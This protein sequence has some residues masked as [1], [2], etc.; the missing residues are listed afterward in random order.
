[1]KSK[2]LRN[3]LIFLMMLGISVLGFAKGNKDSSTN[4]E[5]LS[6]IPQTLPDWSEERPIPDFGFSDGNMPPEPPEPPEGFQKDFPENFKPENMGNFPGKPGEFPPEMMGGE[7]PVNNA[8]ENQSSRNILTN[9]DDKLQNNSFTSTVEINLSNAIINHYGNASENTVDIQLNENGYVLSSSLKEGLNIK[10]SGKLEG[11]FTVDS[12]EDVILLTLDNV[13][14][15]AKD[16]PAI[17]LLTKEK[18][19]ITATKNSENFLT[20]SENRE[21]NTKKG[22]LYAKGAL[23]FDSIDSKVGTITVNGSYKHGVYSDDYIKINDGNLNV[24][25]SARDAVRSINGFIMNEGKLTIRGT[26]TNIDEESK[27]IKVDGEESSEY[28]GEGFIVI[29]NGKIDIET[30]GKAITASWEAEDDAKTTE[31]TDDPNPYLT[32]N[33]G[34]INIVTTAIPY[35]KTLEDGTEVSCSPEGLESKSDLTINGGKIKIRTPDDA[36]NAAISI[37]INDGEIDIVTTQ[38]DAIDSN[39]TLTINGGTVYVTGGSG[40][41]T[42]FDSDMYPFSVNGGTIVGLGGGNISYPNQNSKSNVVVWFAETE[43][44]Q[45]ITVKDSSGKKIISY[46]AEGNGESVIFSSENLI[47]GETYTVSNGDTEEKFTIESNITTI[48][49]KQ[50]FGMP[51]DFNEKNG[52]G[53]RNIKN[54]N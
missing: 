49:T 45:T 42:A 3:F 26:G 44:G 41:E 51:K 20:D 12:S 52:R 30:V 34:E 11:T 2:L 8:A 15:N 53:N 28:A 10:L 16:G 23:I 6:K 18:T 5:D 50:G 48:G 39:G 32:I 33:G 46:K 35:E 9:Q 7:A 19:F 17:N 24:N 43:K 4:E 31:T 37:T 29:N 38:N 40:A 54:R 21:K 27:G 1:M 36:I 25:I 13:I 47:K 22:A 14:I